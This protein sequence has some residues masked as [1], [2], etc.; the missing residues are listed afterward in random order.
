MCRGAEEAVDQGIIPANKARYRGDFAPMVDCACDDVEVQELGRT[1]I[2]SVR[3]PGRRYT[4]TSSVPFCLQGSRLDR[5]Y[6]PWIMGSQLDK[7]KIVVMPQRNWVRPNDN[8]A[9]G[10]NSDAMCACQGSIVLLGR[11]QDRG[12]GTGKRRDWG[13]RASDQRGWRGGPTRG[14]NVG[15]KIRVCGRSR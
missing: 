7:Y 8:E 11:K 6:L 4:P 9:K 1:R 15:G 13:K 12:I 14:W 10:R 2:P 5:V 3:I